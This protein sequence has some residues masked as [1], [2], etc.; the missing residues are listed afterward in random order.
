MYNNW[1]KRKS[2][3]RLNDKVED[4]SPKLKQRDKEIKTRRDKINPRGSTLKYPER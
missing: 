1:S 3:E 4:L 2:I